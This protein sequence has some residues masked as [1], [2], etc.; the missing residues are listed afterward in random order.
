MMGSTGGLLW[1][2]ETALQ[3]T[4]PERLLIFFPYVFSKEYSTRWW[5]RFTL[6]TNMY[7]TYTRRRKLKQNMLDKR[8][9]RYRL[10]Q[11]QV[12]NIEPFTLPESLGESCFLTFSSNG[13]PNILVTKRPFPG[14]SLF[15]TQAENEINFVYTLKPFLMRLLGETYRPAFVERLQKQRIFWIGVLLLSILFGCSSFWVLFQGSWLC[16]PIGFVAVNMAYIS[17]L[18]IKAALKKKK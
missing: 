1:E 6:G 4:N 13:N 11:Q 14:G 18:F 12:E 5:Y 10:F 17:I 7:K 16:V 3:S 8:V 9:K 2:I 15:E